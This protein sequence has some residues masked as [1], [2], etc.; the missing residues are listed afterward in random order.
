MRPWDISVS[1]SRIFSSPSVIPRWAST[2]K[3]I[4]SASS[5]PPQAAA[6]IARSNRRRGLNSPGVS[7]KTICVLPSIATPRIRARVV[8]TL[9]VTIDTLAPTIWFNKVDLPAFGSPIKATNPARVMTSPIGSANLVQHFVLPA[10]LS[11]R[12]QTVRS[13]LP[14]ALKW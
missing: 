10:A 1:V 3:T 13:H 8:C 7:T 6:T 11:Q 4:I 5:A 14:T 12:L 9:W 2:S